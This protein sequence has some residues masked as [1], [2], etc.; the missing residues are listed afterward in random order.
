LVQELLVTGMV[1]HGEASKL[2][3]LPNTLFQTGVIVTI[4]VQLELLTSNSM[5]MSTISRAILS[6]G[7]IFELLG[8]MLAVGFLQHP[9]HNQMPKLL[10]QGVR[11]A[12]RLPLV[13]ISFGIVGLAMVLLMDIF[14]TSY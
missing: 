13:L 9:R 11:F 12:E 14:K 5:A 2:L 8:T 6:L 7:I 1:R 10:H 4:Q 3:M